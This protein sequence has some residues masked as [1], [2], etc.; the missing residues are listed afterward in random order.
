MTLL[1]TALIPALVVLYY[2]YNKDRHPEP[3]GWVAMVFVFGAMSTLVTLPLEIWA[4]SL[5]PVAEARQRGGLLFLECLLIPG[6]IE[7]SIKLLVVVLV[8]WWLQDFDEPIDGLIY[9]TAAALGFTFAE[10]WY[11]YAIKGEDWTRILS[12]VAHPW[13]SCF[14]ASGLGW[15]RTLPRPQGISLAVLGLLA[16]IFVHGL[17]DFL[18]LAGVQD[19]AWAWLRHLVAPLL[20]VLYV[21]VEK[22]LEEGQAPATKPEPEP[23][24]VPAP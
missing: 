16:S 18:L 12:T 13:F 15:A 22:Q 3:W 7:E 5:F 2:Y 14:W 6:L 8:V 20:V 4:Q 19:Q 17:Y 9:G 1:L 24:N 10:D 11:A 23:P 21:V